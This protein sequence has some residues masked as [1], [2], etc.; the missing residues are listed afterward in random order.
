[1]DTMAIVPALPGPAFPGL[2]DGEAD[3]IR[4]AA[5]QTAEL[6]PESAHHQ[7][8]SD[9]QLPLIYIHGGKVTVHSIGD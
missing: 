2:A 9:H 6:V 4:R 5:A 8:N 3:W 7:L 1:M